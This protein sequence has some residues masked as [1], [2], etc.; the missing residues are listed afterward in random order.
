[1]PDALSK[2]QRLRQQGTLNAHPERVCADLFRDRSFFDPDDLLQVRYEAVRAARQG[3]SS[4]A[5]TAR[6]HGLSR[7]TLHRLERR[8]G[9]QGLAG[10]VPRK[11]G[12]RGPHKISDEILRFVEEQ[13]A[14]RG[15]LGSTV[16][17]REIE[18]RFG[19]SIHR[20]SLD[21]ALARRAKK[22]PPEN[23]P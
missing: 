22:S 18:A 1:M 23:R 12:P 17:A 14:A 19:V 11:R 10:L 15:R 3:R 9:E 21:Q 20:V 7:H 6:E 4:R 5:E 13:R 16:L 2:R 8:F